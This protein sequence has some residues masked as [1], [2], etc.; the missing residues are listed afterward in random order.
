LGEVPG[1]LVEGATLPAKTLAEVHRAAGAWLQTLHA[2]PH[3]ESDP[4]ALSTALQE[5]LGRWSE[6][7]T[8]IVRAHTLAWVKEQMADLQLDR[9]RRVPCHRDFWPRNWLWD[10]A[11][12]LGVIDF[13]HALPDL[14]WADIGR[15]VDESW[16]AEPALEGAFWE[17]YGRTPNAAERRLGRAYRAM[18]AIGTITWARAHADIPFETQGWRVLERLGAPR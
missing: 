17:G 9:L 13:E 8:G 11:H 5:R 15:L 4:M 14:W 3:L 16:F 18:A 1:G 10:E 2:L 7:A 12:G 6:R